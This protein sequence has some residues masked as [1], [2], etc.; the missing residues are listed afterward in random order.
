MLVYSYKF[1]SPLFSIWPLQLLNFDS[2]TGLT[3]LLSILDWTGLKVIDWEREADDR[4]GLAATCPGQSATQHLVSFIW[5][6]VI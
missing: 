4:S 5:G 3:G 2:R 6:L 1:I